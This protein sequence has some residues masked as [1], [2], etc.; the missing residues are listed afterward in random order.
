MRKKAWLGALFGRPDGQAWSE[1]EEAL[2]KLLSD[3]AGRPGSDSMGLFAAEGSRRLVDMGGS[4]PKHQTE[5]K[6]ARAAR[7]FCKRVRQMALGF[8]KGTGKER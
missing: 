7:K 3:L 2:L 1:R 8:S 5:T 4:A 6:P